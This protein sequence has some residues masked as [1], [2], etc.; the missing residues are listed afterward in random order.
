M[1]SN[2]QYASLI[3]MGCSPILCEAAI[4]S[5]KSQDLSAL[6][7]WISDHSEEEEKWKAWVEEQRKGGA[8]STEG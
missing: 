8:P 2:P 7:D 1:E 4:R 6:L 3:D 5:L